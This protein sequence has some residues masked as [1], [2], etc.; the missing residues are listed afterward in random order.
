MET[1]ILKKI[2]EELVQ[3]R[4]ELHAIRSSKGFDSLAEH[5]IDYIEKRLLEDA[6]KKTD[7]II[8]TGSIDP[9]KLNI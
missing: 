1:V 2:Y 6:E 3:I 5:I 4:K 9:S 7:Y 8:R